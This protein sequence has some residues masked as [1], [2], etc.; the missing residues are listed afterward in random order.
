[1]ETTTNSWAQSVMSG[2]LTN[3]EYFLDTCVYINYGYPK[4]DF[5]EAAL[6]FFGKPYNKYTSNSVIVEIEN[7]KAFMSR[8]GRDLNKSL[9]PKNTGQVF[10]NPYVIF[11]GYNENQMSFIISF[12]ETVKGRPAERILEEYRSLKTLVSDRMHQALSKT[13]QPYVLPSKDSTFL[14][15]ISY[16]Q[17]QDDKQIIAD[18][19]LWSTQFKYAYLCT[20]D[21][22]HILKKKQNL[23]LDITKHYGRNCLVFVHLKNA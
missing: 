1:M 19:A 9:S 22:G 12:I 5:H 20:S 6:T 8:F 13:N 18:A 17:D 21:E 7:F 4:D 10:K 16:I 23:E 11:Q 14:Q 3:N 2:S 15:Q